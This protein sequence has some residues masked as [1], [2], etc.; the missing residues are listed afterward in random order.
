MKGAKLK[1]IKSWMAD[2]EDSLQ[3]VT[4]HQHISSDPDWIQFN[5]LL[6]QNLIRVYITLTRE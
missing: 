1:R 5:S 2:A 3:T 4:D 6:Y